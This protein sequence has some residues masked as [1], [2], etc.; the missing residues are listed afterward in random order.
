MRCDQPLMTEKCGQAAADLER[1]LIQ[2]AFSSL[3]DLLTSA[4]NMDFWPESCSRL[5]DAEDV[6]KIAATGNNKGGPR[7]STVGQGQVSN[8]GEA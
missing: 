4:T 2:I 7:N 5:G 6:K 1:N 8:N 3:D